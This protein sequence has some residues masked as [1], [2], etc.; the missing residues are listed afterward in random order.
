MIVTGKEEPFVPDPEDL[1]IWEE[2]IR[3]KPS[4]VI[5]R[6]KYR[7]RRRKRKMYERTRVSPTVRGFRSV[8]VRRDT[9]EMLF[10]MKIFYKQ[11][12]SKMLHKLV[13]IAYD[14]TYKQAELLARIE[15][16]REKNSVSPYVDKPGR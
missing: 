13:S 3:P 9:Y 8:M 16:N 5:P 12:F 11:S 1:R 15:Q 2:Y 6:E 4:T 14:K 7:R 10:E